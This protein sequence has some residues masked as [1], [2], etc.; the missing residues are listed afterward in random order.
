MWPSLSTTYGIKYIFKCLIR[1]IVYKCHIR[2]AFR[3]TWCLTSM[4]VGR[5][6]IRRSQSAWATFTTLIDSTHSFSV[7][8]TNRP[9]SSIRRAEYCRSARTKPS[10]MPASIRGHCEDPERAYSLVRATLNRRKPFSTKSQRS[11][12]LELRGND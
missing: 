4:H 12:D 7:F 3:S 8:T 9:T 5:T 1:S 11:V 2:N 10:L 6:T